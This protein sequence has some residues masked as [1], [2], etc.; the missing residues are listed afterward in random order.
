MKR[1]L[2][3]KRTC[4]NALAV[5]LAL[6]AFAC[7]G[8]DPE[9]TAHV[10]TGDVAG[11]DVRVGIIA[12]T[13]HARVFFCG[14]ASSYMTMTRWLNADIDA[15]HK[16]S[17]PATPNQYWGLQGDVADTEIGGTVDMGDSVPRVFR[18]TVVSD[19]TI[20]GLYEGT[21]GCGRLGLIVVQPTSDMPAIG[22]GA[23]VGPG[24]TLEQVNPL[25]PIVRSPDGTITVTVSNWTGER[26]VRPATPPAD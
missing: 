18:A 17:L 23:C 14:G 19:R 22:Q 1:N 16:L 25:D 12:S 6:T 7:G 15:G 3:S 4:Q 9:A 5:T 2:S 21:A 20:S 24:T 26:Q 10:Y 8:R 11:T 13:H